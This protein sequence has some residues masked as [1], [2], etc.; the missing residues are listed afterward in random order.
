MFKPGL[1]TV[2][3][4]GAVG[5]PIAKTV[6]EH[7]PVIDSETWEDQ[8]LLIG[9]GRRPKKAK[10]KKKKKCTNCVCAIC[11]ALSICTLSCPHEAQHFASERLI[12]GKCRRG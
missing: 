8:D 7:L 5:I 4:V 3:S 2:T 11:C 10:K 9:S 12:C 1:E 6:Y